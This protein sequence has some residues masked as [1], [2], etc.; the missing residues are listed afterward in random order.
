MQ[1]IPRG[2]KIPAK[3]Q[4]RRVLRH[5]ETCLVVIQRSRPALREA[6]RVESLTEITWAS[7]DLY[8]LCADVADDDE[9]RSLVSQARGTILATLI[10]R[11]SCDE[12]V[13]DRLGSGGRARKQQRL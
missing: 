1:K 6:R 5:V 8:T 4:A 12:R 2:G 10:E 13:G 11:A 3:L 9:L 7:L